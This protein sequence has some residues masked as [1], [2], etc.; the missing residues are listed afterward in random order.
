MHQ[1]ISVTEA[2]RNF[3]DVINRVYYQ[4]QTY[5]LTR[6]GI[7][8][9]QLAGAHKTLSAKELLRRWEDRPRLTP[10]DAANWGQDLVEIR[11]TFTLPEKTAWDY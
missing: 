5:L 2:S 1:E 3:S 8:V 4:G 9:A 11:T 10:E 7:V 6:G